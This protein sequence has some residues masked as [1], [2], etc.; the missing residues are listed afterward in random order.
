MSSSYG[1]ERKRKEGLEREKQ[2]NNEERK[3]YSEIN[4]DRSV[5]KDD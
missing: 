3:K 2:T 4:E 1:K 5:K